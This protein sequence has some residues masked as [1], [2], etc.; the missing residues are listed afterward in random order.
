MNKSLITIYILALL[1]AFT[2]CDDGYVHEKEFIDTNSGYNVVVTGTFKSLKNWSNTYSVALA[3]YGNESDYSLVQKSLPANSNDS[4]EIQMEMVNINTAAKTIEIAV[5]NV[6]R[7]RIATIYSYDIP[8][9]QS[10]HDTIR[11]DVG[12]LNVGMFSAI[13]KFV[14]QGSGSSCSRCHAANRPTAQLD[15]SEDNAYMSLVNQPSYKNSNYMRVKP[16]DA[17]NSYLY[18]VI[19]DGVPEIKYNHPGI[20]ADEKYTAFQTIIKDWINKG[21]KE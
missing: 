3:A 20:F 5:V 11:I 12:E 1:T 19:T 17:E 8:E 10:I 18:R 13:N 21:A 16:G 6:L 4:T 14:F 9:D 7:Q 15:L 2:S